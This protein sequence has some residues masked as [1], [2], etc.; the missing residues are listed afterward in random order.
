MQL[1][2]K[3]LLLLCVIPLLSCSNQDEY[4]ENYVIVNEHENKDTVF[5]SYDY[6]MS[7]TPSS[8]SAQ[9]AACYGDYFF[10]G[11]AGNAIVDIYD[12]RKKEKIATI[13]NPYRGNNTHAN[14]ICFGN[15]KYDSTDY[16]PLLYIS[17]GYTSLIEDISCSF[18]YI[19]RII[20]K[21]TENG[22]EDFSMEYINKII[23]KDMGT[24]TE[25]IFDNENNFLWIKYQPNREYRY[26]SFAIP[27][28]ENGDVTLTLDDTITDF[29]I[30]IQ[31]F[32]SYNQGHI[33]YKDRILLVSGTSPYKQTLAFI[34]INTK[35]NSREFVVDIGRLGFR[36]EPESICI[37]DNNI[38][39]G[40]ATSLYK[41]SYSVVKQ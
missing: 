33:Y 12:L 15:R 16:F 4:I 20:K 9:G 24:W 5:F 23:L 18:I 37:Y 31:P 28:F 30:G 21:E 17:S 19:Y 7:L 38:M 34:G 13:K 8:T 32:L 36:E 11:F 14:S 29:S 35:S 6:Y 2:R 26:A 10:Q 39:V 41:V 27:D 22:S 25:G 3:I 1:N 40:S